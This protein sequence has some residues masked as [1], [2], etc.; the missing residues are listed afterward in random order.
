MSA[1]RFAWYQAQSSL[2]N[3]TV[4]PIQWRETRLCQKVENLVSTTFRDR[5]KMSKTKWCFNVIIN[6][7]TWFIGAWTCFSTIWDLTIMR[8]LLSAILI[9]VIS[10]LLSIPILGIIFWFTRTSKPTHVKIAEEGFVEDIIYATIWMQKVDS[11]R[12]NNSGRFQ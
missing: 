9:I 5:T 8:S 7:V 10:G 4:F 3:W 12:N 1:G 2:S 11:A 6:N